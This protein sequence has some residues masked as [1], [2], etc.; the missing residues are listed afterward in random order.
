MEDVVEAN[1]DA[2]VRKAF[3]DFPADVR[4]Q[5]LPDDL[6]VATRLIKPTDD[7]Y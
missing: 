2:T 6:G 5:Y 1:I 4:C 3:D 7:R